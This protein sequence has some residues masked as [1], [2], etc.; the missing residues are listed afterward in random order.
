MNP[1]DTIVIEKQMWID[2][3][4][5]IRGPMEHHQPNY[6]CIVLTVGNGYNVVEAAANGG[7]DLDTVSVLHQPYTLANHS[8]AINKSI[9]NK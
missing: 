5:T 8:G 1:G 7:V 9:T 4:Q 2:G 6:D 3:A